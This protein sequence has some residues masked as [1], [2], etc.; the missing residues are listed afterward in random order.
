MKIGDPET[1]ARAKE[2]A[3][4]VEGGGELMAWKAYPDG[5]M[6]L[7]FQ[8]G[9]IITFEKD[10]KQEPD[11]T[12]TDS[13]VKQKKRTEQFVEDVEKEIKKFGQEWQTDDDKEFP[14]PKK[15]KE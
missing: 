15:K 11:N 5:S 14:F 6:M 3:A 13:I 12:L 7:V 2:L 8:D 4:T 10:G 1:H 9:R